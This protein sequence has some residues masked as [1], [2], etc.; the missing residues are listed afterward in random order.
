MRYVYP[1]IEHGRLAE[2]QILLM[3][4]I[5]IEQVFDALKPHQVHKARAVCEMS[6]QPAPSA[7]ASSLET[8]DFT[9][10]LDIRHGSIYLMNGIDAASVHI[11][12]GEIIEQIMERVDSKLLAQQ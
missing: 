12:I 5:F 3:H 6:Y 1:S 10:Q 7:F 9:F 8:H 2:D 11:L 4:L